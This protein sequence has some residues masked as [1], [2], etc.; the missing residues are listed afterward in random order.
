[1]V[2]GNLT[3]FGWPAPTGCQVNRHNNNMPMA[4]FANRFVRLIVDMHKDIITVISNPWINIE[5][6]QLEKNL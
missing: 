4:L 5:T 2:I 1:M 3:I 6:F